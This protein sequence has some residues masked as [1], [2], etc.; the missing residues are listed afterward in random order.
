VI[1]TVAHVPIRY[2]TAAELIVRPAV[3]RERIQPTVVDHASRL[4]AH[5]L[6][7]ATLARTLAVTRRAAA[8]SD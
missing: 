6:A 4:I 1:E 3:N 5:A 8:R 2:A 7:S